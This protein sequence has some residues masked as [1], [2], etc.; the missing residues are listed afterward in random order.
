MSQHDLTIANQ[1]FPAF[2]AD[3]NDALQA[4]GSCQSGTSAPSPTF[5]NQL[6]YDTTNNILKIRNEDNDA[7][8]SIATLDQA[9][10]VLSVITLNT[11]NEGTSG[12]GV[13]VDGV[14]LKDNAVTASADSTISGLTVGKGT[15]SLALNTAV[16]AGALA[17]TNTGDGQCSA[18]GFQVLNAN[19][20]GAYNTG[21]GLQALLS[22]TTGSSNVSV[23]GA[24]LRT[25]TS[26]GNNTAVGFQALNANTTA[27]GNTA[28]GYQAGY[29]NTTGYLNTFIGYNA[30][31]TNSTGLANTAI[32]YNSLRLCTVNSNTAVGYASLAAT[33]TGASNGGFGQEAL[34]SNTTGTMNNAV[35]NSA[36]FSNTTG[37]YNCAFGQEA[38]RGN[39]VGSYNTAVGYQSLYSN[40]GNGAYTA[41]GYQAGFSTTTGGD[42]TYVGW[43]AGYDVTTGANNVCIGSYA[44]RYLTG[45][46]TGGQNI[47]L[48]AYT[49]AAST[50][51]NYQIVIGYGSISKG[52]GTGYINPGSGGVYQGNN[53]ST[54]LQTSDQRLK[55]NIVDNN[56]GL[57][58]INAIQ[59]RNFE[60]RLPEEVTELE[61]HCAIDVKGVQLGAIA[62]ELQAVL[63]DCV[64]EEST[65]VLR[66]D[67][68]NLTWYLINAVKELKAEIDLIKGK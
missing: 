17:S 43:Q 28:V 16:G 31:Y 60:Y 54:W 25:N 34:T 55:K 53:S 49:G 35:G 52:A 21:F 48:G 9:N 45:I 11:I 51:A 7:W 39:T 61:S 32:G 18:F 23:G 68:D 19:T 40:T 50:S 4:L 46:V 14:L 5:A 3:L 20:S 58:V 33:T 12:S 13:T 65:G 63:P 59:V 30:G 57:D 26:G 66:V 10:D 38:L 1:G 22:N 8:I 47:M 42:A 27:S 2:R 44:G 15:G 64:K 24:S 67:T 37:N 62:Q 29:L 36:L 6:W 56:T 41:V